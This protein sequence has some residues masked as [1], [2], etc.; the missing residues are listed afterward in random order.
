[1]TARRESRSFLGSVST[2]TYFSG[3]FF[4]NLFKGLFHNRFKY[5]EDLKIYLNFIIDP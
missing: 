3:L 2:I 1:M 4:L 5:V